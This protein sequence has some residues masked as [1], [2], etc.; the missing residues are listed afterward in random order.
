[1]YVWFNPVSYQVNE[2]DGVVTLNI[3]RRGANAIPVNVSV[4]SLDINA[5]GKR[6]SI[7]KINSNKNT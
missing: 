2:E 4:T 1:M 7:Q 6:N 5:T 3:E